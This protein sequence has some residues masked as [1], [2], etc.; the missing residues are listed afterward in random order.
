MGLSRWRMDSRNS[1][2]SLGTESAEAASTSTPFPTSPTSRAQCHPCETP[3]FECSGCVRGKQWLGILSTYPVWRETCLISP[4][5]SRYE[6]GYR[7]DVSSS[8]SNGCRTL[9]LLPTSKASII[10][11]GRKNQ[12]GKSI[13]LPDSRDLSGGSSGRNVDNSVQ[14][15]IHPLLRK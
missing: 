7:C 5:S 1:N 14:P 3:L 10:R 15:P 13:F 6:D 11:F 8:I 2:S 9:P 4:I 12:E